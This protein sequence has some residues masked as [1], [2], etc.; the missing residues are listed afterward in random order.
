MTRRWHVR[1]CVR[2][3][4]E[5]GVGAEAISLRTARYAPLQGG[6]A[7]E[8][9]G[10][11][12]TPESTGIV[13]CSPSCWLAVIDYSMAG[14]RSAEQLSPEDSKP[15]DQ[16]GWRN[17]GTRTPQ[18]APAESRIAWGVPAAWPPEGA[19]RFIR[20]GE[21]VL[22]KGWSDS[23][24]HYRQRVD[25]EVMGDGLCCTNR[26]PIPSEGHRQHYVP[27][28]VPTSIFRLSAGA[29]SRKSPQEP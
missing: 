7:W 14:V 20:S 24:A 17:Q 18:N 4:A 16:K 8:A 1:P 19:E 27:W 9:G 2:R 21:W 12:T 22:S 11:W 15:H 13:L 23:G 29:R 28:Q 5:L 10:D 3:G 6:P 25:S 26:R